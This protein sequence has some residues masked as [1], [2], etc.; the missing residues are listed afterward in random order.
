MPTI[1]ALRSEKE[2]LA[3]IGEARVREPRVGE[4]RVGEA[5]RIPGEG[6]VE[7]AQIV[8]SA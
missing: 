8:H 7:G 6:G 5:G 3:G 1:G 2:Q 4:A